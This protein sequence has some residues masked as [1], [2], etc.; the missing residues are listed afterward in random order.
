MGETTITIN[1][2]FAD[3]KAATKFG[4]NFD[5]AC[6]ANHHD[7]GNSLKDLFDLEVANKINVESVETENS[8]IFISC[9]GGRH[10]EQPVWFVEALSGLGANRIELTSQCDDSNVTFYFI[11]GRRVS[12]SKFFGT[13]KPDYLEQLTQRELDRIYLP[14]G[15]TKVEA[16]LIESS[17]DTG[18]WSHSYVL[19][20]QTSDGKDFYYRGDSELVN[21]VHYDDRY[22]NHCSFVAKFELEKYKGE[23]LSFAKRP[24]KIE[25]VYRESF[26]KFLPKATCP[27][28]GKTLRTDKAK[29]CMHCLKSWHEK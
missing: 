28:C 8:S 15:R 20:M 11:G 27:F 13:T 17:R 9:Y 21:L 14:K 4:L 5:K 16:E 29:Q 7:L 10:I 23:I 24:S 25:F 1:S 2:D 12:K 18:E 22:E 3:E 26:L 6:N 19:K